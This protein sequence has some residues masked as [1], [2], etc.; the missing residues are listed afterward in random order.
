MIEN[1]PDPD[2]TRARGFHNRKSF[3]SIAGH[4]YL[5][6]EVDHA[7]RRAEIYRAAGGEV[8][9]VLDAKGKHVLEARDIRPA[10][11]QGCQKP[12]RVTWRSGEWDHRHGGNGPSR[13]DCP[14]NGRYVC[15]AWHRARHPR[16]LWTPKSRS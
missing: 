2:A 7:L 6:G 4:E 10:T 11:C 3:V 16:V 15:S 1:R 8:D 5:D 9:I 14:H 12:H 13:C